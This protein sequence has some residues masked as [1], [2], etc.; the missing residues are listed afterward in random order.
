MD[1]HE[2]PADDRDAP[3]AEPSGRRP[4]AGP[5]IGAGIAIGVGVGVALYG[6]TGSPVWIALGLGFGLAIG[7]GMQAKK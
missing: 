3:E 5:T 6:A 7:A 1:E 2:T 4:A